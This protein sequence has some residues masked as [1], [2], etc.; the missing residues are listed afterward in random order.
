M[1]A[2]ARQP[3]P[4][5]F[6]ALAE[7]A[8][9]PTARV[10]L[11]RVAGQGAAAGRLIAV[12]RLHAHVAQ[13]PQFVTM[14]EDEVWMTAALRHPNVVE[15]V[16]WGHD[17]EGMYLAVELVEGVSLARL[18]KTVF[19]TGEAFTER[20]VV[21][22]GAELSGGL[23][24][25][26]ALRSTTGE[27]LQLVHRD[28]TPGNVLIGFAGQTKITD[29]GLAKAKQRL[30]KTLTGLLKGHPQYMAP[31]QARA[32]ALD[33]RADLFS[34]GVL[35]FELFTGVHPWSSGSE[36]EVFE[37][38]ATRPHADLGELRPKIDRELVAVVHQLLEKDPERRPRT[39]AEVRSR[40]LHWLDIHG[41]AEGNDDALG[42]FVRRNAMRQ[43]R[44]FERAVAGEFRDVDARHGQVPRAEPS[45]G[46]PSVSRRARGGAEAGTS[47]HETTSAS[48]AR[49]R[50][51]RA[52]AED[53]TDVGPRPA[54]VFDP[55]SVPSMVDSG[56]EW[57][58]EV[59]TI[60]QPTRSPAAVRP[61]PPPRVAG[62]RP[63]YGVDDESDQRA[64]DVH[65]RSG[66]QPRAASGALARAASAD[67]HDDPEELPTRPQRRP[68]L[69]AYGRGP[70]P[71]GPPA[72]QASS[73]AASAEGESLRI[74]AQRVLAHA[75]LLR[76]R[77]D[78]AAKRAA[79][80]A[81]LAQLGADAAQLASD[82]LQLL[83]AGSASQ[84]SGL[85]SEARRI[86]QSI[87]RGE[88]SLARDAVEASE[89][90]ASSAASSPAP[91]RA[92][93]AAIEPA[94]AGFRGSGGSP[95]QGVL[96][97][98]TPPQFDG[99][100][101]APPSVRPAESEQL[102]SPVE[103]AVRALKAEVLGLPLWLALGLA[104]ALALA[105]VMLVALLLG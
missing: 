51:R 98:R 61:G 49:R 100:P 48:P 53:A 50:L 22:I 84:A 91:T 85:L 81:V 28:L 37:L 78:A 18:M 72:L 73:G 80:R 67:E 104:F 55:S 97:L 41:Y 29:F 12:K 30:S 14:F 1:S 56:A 59:P 26:H 57:S 43:M 3:S 68:D 21:H 9:G 65:A 10:D 24:A 88:T 54:G 44:W 33:G 82:A 90:D 4:L 101:S 25:A 23:A 99:R 70:A 17:A 16:G 52:S 39:A 62:A 31:E 77:A 64:T 63:P 105:M 89:D 102:R 46:G 20:M 76:E 7:I 79:H 45:R 66:A 74:E 35:L 92:S 96:L 42:R 86:E 15:V 83:A 93:F 38:V 71:P 27:S 69:S 75:H 87:T 58:E 6:E 34:L 13:D 36:L 2:G 103:G 94:A 40:L 5:V 95:R 47:R 19:E 8:T 60:V 32:E 11:C